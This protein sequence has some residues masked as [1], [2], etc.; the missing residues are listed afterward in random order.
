MKYGYA[1]VSTKDQNTDRQLEAL[2]E[3]G[4]DEQKIFVDKATGSNFDR[5]AYKEMIETLKRNDEIFV[6]SIDRLG[7]DYDEIIQQRNI[8]TKNRSRYCCVGF[9]TFGYKRK[10]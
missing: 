5:V 1:R 8:I 2:I 10:N 3:S 7:R 9:S 4:V 6:R